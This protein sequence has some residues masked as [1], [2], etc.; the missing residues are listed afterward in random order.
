[1]ITRSNSAPK[2]KQVYTPRV[3]DGRLSNDGPGAHYYGKTGGRFTTA[4][5]HYHYKYPSFH[6]VLRIVLP[7]E[8]S[9][10][11]KFSTMSNNLLSRSLIS[12]PLKMNNLRPIKMLLKQKPPQKI[13]RKPSKVG[14]CNIPLNKNME[15]I[16]IDL[17]PYNC[18]GLV[19]SVLPPLHSKIQL[20]SLQP[21]KRR[22]KNSMT[23]LK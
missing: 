6:A 23:S 2:M 21:S 18:N 1:M 22:S 8:S 11:K 14:S 9:T 20:S 3:K 13:S 7:R 15:H 16:T 5:P 12:S 19:A 17:S 10:L 4:N